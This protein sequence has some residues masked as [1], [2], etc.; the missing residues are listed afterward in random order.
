MHQLI[1]NKRPDGLTSSAA[2]FTLGPGIGPL[3][4]TIEIHLKVPPN[5]PCKT[6]M[7]RNQYHFFLENYWTLEFLPIGRPLMAWKSAHEAHIQPTSKSSSNEHVKQYWY[8]TSGN[9]LRQEQR[10]MP[11][12]HWLLL[13]VYGTALW[14]CERVTLWNSLGCHFVWFKLNTTLYRPHSTIPTCGCGLSV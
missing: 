9:F 2:N 1:Q 6:T 4:H 3:V 13:S 11:K 10:W 8:E 14:D 5:D 7:M 12:C